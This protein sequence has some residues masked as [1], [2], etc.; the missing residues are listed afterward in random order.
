MSEAGSQTC[1]LS[2]RGTAQGG[3][4]RRTSSC[5]LRT[6]VRKEPSADSALLHH[7]T[8]SKQ[9]GFSTPV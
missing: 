6:S 8:L 9:Y 5:T 7:F 1:K 4:Q 2:H 3:E